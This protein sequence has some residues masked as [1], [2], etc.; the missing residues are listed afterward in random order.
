MDGHQ[1]EL[2][3]LTRGPK[4]DEEFCRFNEENPHVFKKFRELAVKIK[5]KGHDKWGA[6]SLW[7][8]LRWELAM[9]TNAHVDAPKLNNNLTSRMARKLVA[10][11]EDEW[12]GFFDLRKLKH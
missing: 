6:K 11:D 12:G 1:P 3:P 5:A 2:G 4:L 10:E 9:E 7:E 8:I